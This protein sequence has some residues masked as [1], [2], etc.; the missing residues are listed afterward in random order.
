MG[1]DGITFR[2]LNRFY[3][4]ETCKD[5]KGFPPQQNQQGIAEQ[6]NGEEQVASNSMG[7]FFSRNHPGVVLKLVL[8]HLYVQKE[9]Y[10]IGDKRN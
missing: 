8:P 1:R 6:Q 4:S 5:G 9:L 10:Y 3:W 7:P 2:I